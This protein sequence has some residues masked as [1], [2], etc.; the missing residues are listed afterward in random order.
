MDTRG[1][2][3][4]TA[5]VRRVEPA[6]RSPAL[7]T[8]IAVFLRTIGQIAPYDTGR[9][10]NA[11]ASAAADIGI[12]DP[13]HVPLRKGRFHAKIRSVLIRQHYFWQRVLDNEVRRNAPNSAGARQARSRL[14]RTGRE[15]NRFIAAEAQGHAILGFDI[16]G[17]RLGLR[18]ATVRVNFQKYGGRGWMRVGPQYTDIILQNRE[19]HV[20]IVEKR[21]GTF[22]RARAASMSPGQIRLVRD[23]WAKSIALAALDAR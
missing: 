2:M 9:Y 11:W 23:K 17:P 7:A 19:P 8:P 21:Y 6:Q 22:K 16:L 1:L 20:W 3:R 4:T 18:I 14:K 15:L 12:R 10:R 13:G 5:I